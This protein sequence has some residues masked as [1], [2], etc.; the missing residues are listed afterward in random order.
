MKF[1]FTK[2]DKD[3]WS[4]EC[5]FFLDVSKSD[6]EILNC[7]PLLENIAV[8]NEALNG[9]RDFYQFLKLMRREFVAHFKP[10]IN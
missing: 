8:I 4:R 1:V 3:D 5:S 7:T 6:Y 2:I 9:N 10:K